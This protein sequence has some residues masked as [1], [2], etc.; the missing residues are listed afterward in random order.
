MYK[1]DLTKKELEYVILESYCSI[2]NVKYTSY[3]HPMYHKTSRNIK[4]YELDLKFYDDKENEKYRQH[5]K[6]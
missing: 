2:E 6:E 1:E 4:K 5:K 3:I